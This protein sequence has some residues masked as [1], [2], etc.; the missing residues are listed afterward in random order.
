M[1]ID[2]GAGDPRCNLPKFRDRVVIEIV[3]LGLRIKGSLSA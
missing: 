2:D 3:D 1:S